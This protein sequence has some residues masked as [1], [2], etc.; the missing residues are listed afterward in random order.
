MPKVPPKVEEKMILNNLYGKFGEDPMKEVRDQYG[1]LI[2]HAV[3]DASTMTDEEI[4]AGIS[5]YGRMLKCLDD[6]RE[7]RLR[8]N[9]LKMAGKF[10]HTCADP[11]TDFQKLPVLGE[12]F[13]EVCQAVMQTIGLNSSHD[14]PKHLRTELCQVAAVAL[15]WMESLTE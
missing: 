8:Q 1:N 7:E 3:A 10:P 5:S 12:E 14:A 9:Q 13:G 4:R 2:L 6:I 11:I 15:A